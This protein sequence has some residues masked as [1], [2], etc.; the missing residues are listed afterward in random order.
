MRYEIDTIQYGEHRDTYR[1]ESMESLLN[2]LCNI[3]EVRASTE[4]IEIR[5]RGKPISKTRMKVLRALA[6]R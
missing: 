3:Y 6:L 4:I 1:H 5:E 2:D